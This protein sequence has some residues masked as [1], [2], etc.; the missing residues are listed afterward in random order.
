MGEK[1]R[2]VGFRIED[3]RV[4]ERLSNFDSLNYSTEPV[5]TIAQHER[6]VAGLEAR[7]AEAR[8]LL[9]AT[10]TDYRHALGVSQHAYESWVRN[11]VHRQTPMPNDTWARHCHSRAT[12]ID[13][14][15]AQTAEGV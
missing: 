2:V 4:V 13:A 7:L 1:V 8:G 5:M 10:Q 15:L 9:V 14:F 3:G 12:A 11:G 6:I